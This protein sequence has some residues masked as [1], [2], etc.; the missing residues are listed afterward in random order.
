MYPSLFHLGRWYDVPDYPF[1]EQRKRFAFI[2]LLVKTEVALAISR[3]RTE[4]FRVTSMSLFHVLAIK[5]MRMEEFEQTQSQTSSQV[6]IKFHNHTVISLL[7]CKNC[8]LLND[9]ILQ[10]LVFE[11][12]NM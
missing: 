11:F 8:L 9:I 12:A 10:M 4:C 1:R 7:L 5:S 3:V 6:P 2:T